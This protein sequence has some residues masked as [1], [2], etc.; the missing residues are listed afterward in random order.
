MAPTEPLAEQHFATIQ[1][2]MPG[3][4]VP[5]GLLTGST[6]GRRRADLLGKLASGELSLLVGTHALIEDPVRFAAARG[7][8]GR[9][10]APLRRAPARG[11]GRQ[12]GR[13]D[14]AR[15]CCT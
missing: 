6:P 7:R 8:G 15:T 1:A 10:A 11:A 9:R 14:A 5:I 12:G 13:R 4:A 2:L 3:E